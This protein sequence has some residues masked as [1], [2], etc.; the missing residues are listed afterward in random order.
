MTTFA[1]ATI[2]HAAGR[3]DVAVPAGTTLAG[4][5]ALLRIPVGPDISIALPDGTPADLDAALGT[6]LPSGVLL[7]VAGTRATADATARAVQAGDEA[8]F[9]RWAATAGGVG[10]AAVL[11]WG[12]LAAPFLTGVPPLPLPA[13]VVSGV[14]LVAIVLTLLRG[15]GLRG[16]A[17]RG[18]GLAGPLGALGVPALLAPAAVLVSDPTDPAGRAVAL[19][20][21]LLL[22][23]LAAN[24]LHLPGRQPAT[25]A[26]AAVW[27]ALALGVS[28]APLAGVPGTVVAPALL[29]IAVAVVLLAPRFAVGVPESQLLDLPLLTTVAP[30]V[31]TPPVAPP[32]RITR[33]RV[34]R[35][36]AEAAA[37]TDT[38]VL[39]GAVVA[40]AAG[41][42]LLAAVD[43]GTLS[44]Q[45]AL[46]T[47][48]VAALVL[49][50]STRGRRSPV[51]R[52]APVAAATA[53]AGLAATALLR[54]GWSVVA[55]GAGVV[56][57]ALVLVL[58]TLAVTRRPSAL[59]GR[60]ADLAQGLGLVLLLPGAFLA[61]GLFEWIWQAAS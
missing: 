22:A 21:M 60:L 57:L 28:L 26:A 8:W 14:A 18:P 7:S 24:A 13:R 15:P 50:L 33:R 20:A 16:A 61:A 1:T 5:L 54:T 32:S 55:I 37:I 29:V 51:V 49:A 58:G 44:G 46:G 41:A 6:D 39:G 38:C 27:G 10:L 42:V 56:V 34:D 31:R 3:T 48:A 17:L 4:L 2:A 59:P 9:T 52:W 53:L 12:L 45:A 35:T 43:P 23:A 11:G 25:G 40:V 19:A 47:T 30:A 36:V